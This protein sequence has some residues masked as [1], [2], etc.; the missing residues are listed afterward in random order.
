MV[1]PPFCCHV[2]VMINLT[3]IEGC[4]FGSHQ[5]YI[6]HRYWMTVWGRDLKEKTHELTE[7]TAYIWHPGVYAKEWTSARGQA[8]VGA[9]VR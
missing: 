7:V 2:I 6:S 1:H 5:R 3:G 8:I 9:M 4:H